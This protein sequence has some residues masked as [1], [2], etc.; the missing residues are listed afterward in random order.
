MSDLNHQDLN[1]VQ[2]N[3]QPKPTTI[4]STTTIAPTTALTFITGTNAIAQVTPPASGFHILYLWPLA[5]FT[6]TTAGNVTTALTAAV[7][8][9]VVLFYDPIIAKY[10][11]AE[12]GAAA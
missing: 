10:R 1:P 6:M 3:L 4:A 11:P 9:P 2:S 12:I 7:G 5:A 8:S